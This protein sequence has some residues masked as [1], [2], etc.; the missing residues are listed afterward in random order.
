MVTDLQNEVQ[1]CVHVN[2]VLELILPMIFTA[3]GNETKA[4]GGTCVYI[5][6]FIGCIHLH[7]CTTVTFFVGT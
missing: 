2:K 1:M 4:D 5:V 7:A 3:E 6:S